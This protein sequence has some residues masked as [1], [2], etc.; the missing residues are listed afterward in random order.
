[1]IGAADQFAADVQLWIVGYRPGLDA[2]ADLRV[3]QHVDVGVGGAGRV[4][5]ADCLGGE[6]ALR[7][8]RGCPS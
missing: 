6:A 7:R 3:G 1:M 4:Q 8:A 5:R 2:F